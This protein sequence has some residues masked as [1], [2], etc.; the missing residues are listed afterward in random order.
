MFV[1]CPAGQAGL[2]P[3]NSSHNRAGG[4]NQVAPVHTHLEELLLLAVTSV[5]S[6]FS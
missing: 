6:D 3:G 2:G 4:G 5:M 1:Q